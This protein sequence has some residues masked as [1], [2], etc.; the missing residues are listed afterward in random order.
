MTPYHAW[1]L[2]G[3]QR[4]KHI[5]EKIAF[6]V[7]NEVVQEFRETYP[8]AGEAVFITEVAQLKRDMNVFL[9]I[10]NQELGIP[11]FA[12]MVFGLENIDPVPIKLKDGQVIYIRGMIDRVDKI[13]KEYAVWDYKTGSASAYEHRAYVVRGRQIQHALYYKAAEY[14]LQKKDKDARVTVSGYVLPTEKGE[15][16]GRGS[17]FKRSTERFDE[18][19]HALT[20][21]LDSISRG[22]FIKPDKVEPWM[23]DADIF[24][25]KTSVM[26]VKAKM[27]NEDNEELAHLRELKKCK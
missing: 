27:G 11:L 15:R 1:F 22:V 13:G 16:F 9:R 6:A 12:E 26:D 8:P 5:Q 10:N 23:K 25:D 7:L 18:C 21:I 17:V 3:V 4:L 20:L 14:L 24:G 2:L 19:D